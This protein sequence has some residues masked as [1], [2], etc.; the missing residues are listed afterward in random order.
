MQH[1]LQGREEQLNILLEE[2]GVLRPFLLCGKSF[3][4]LPCAA[5]A[6]ARAPRF[7]E[8]AP[9]PDVACVRRA[10]AAFRASGC[11]GL[12]AVGGGSAID[13]AKGV[14]AFL[15]APA[16]LGQPIAE[17]DL[18]LI[19]VPTTAGSGSE[20]TQFAV[21]YDG[22]QKHSAAHPSLLPRGVLLDGELL[23]SLP[24]Y[25]KKCT[26]L[27]AL[28]QGIESHWSRRATA[29]SRA[30]AEAA[31]RGIWSR[32]DDYLAGDKQ[33]AQDML[34]AANLAGQAINR[35][36]TTAPHAMSYKLTTL[37]GLPHGHAVAVCLQAVWRWMEARAGGELRRELDAVAALLGAQNSAE[38]LAAYAALLQK[39]DIQPPALRAED[40]D[41]LAASVNPE[42]LANHPLALGAEE[43]REMY[44]F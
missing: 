4:R 22:G 33:A 32:L 11:D 39:L 8:V 12:V 42:R 44:R 10:I 14:K 35:T 7:Q 24:L 23:F 15:H 40:L 26:L 37:Y 41:T 38:G 9:N 1:I 5:W 6:L 25:Q 43:I 3:D 2:A 29:E 28:C 36:T 21:L 30:L 20:S 13:T 27:D 31:V 16:G 18:P 19:A 34:A 17:N